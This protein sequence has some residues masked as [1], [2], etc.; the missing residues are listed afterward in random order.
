MNPKKPMNVLP[1]KAIQD[2]LLT[3]IQMN[4]TQF[5]DHYQTDIY[6]LRKHAVSIFKAINTGNITN[7]DSYGKFIK[8]ALQLQM[9]EG[10]PVKI[11][12]LKADFGSSENGSVITIANIHTIKGLES[13]ALLAI[14]K[15]E[16]ELLLWIETH[17]SIREAKRD[18]EK[19]D[20][21]RLGYV[22]FSRAEKLLCIACLEKVSDITLRKLEMLG[23]VFDK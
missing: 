7:E 20:Y 16:E 15:T 23:V 1:L 17:H 14:A 13:E 8:E 2:T 12:N 19:T 10:L 11:E 3:T 6:T 5:C 21:P 18:N 4:Q 22:A 9:K